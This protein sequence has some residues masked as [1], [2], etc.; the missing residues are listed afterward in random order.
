MTARDLM[1]GPRPFRDNLVL[2]E[3]ALNDLVGAGLAW[4]RIDSAAA[5]RGW[6]P[7][8]Y[9]LRDAPASASGGDTQTPAPAENGLPID[10]VSPKSRDPG[11]GDA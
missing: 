11:V 6:T 5:P 7:I 3:Q 8:S 9:V 2:S 10:G 1:R 4:R